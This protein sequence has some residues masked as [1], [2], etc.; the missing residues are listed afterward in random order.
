M[1]LLFVQYK[2]YHK[3]VGIPVLT[4]YLSWRRWSLLIECPA[5]HNFLNN[6]EWISISSLNIYLSIVFLGG[7]LR[8]NYIFH[9]TPLWYTFM[10]P[11]C[12]TVRT[13]HVP[14]S[15]AI[16]IPLFRNLARFREGSPAFI[17]E[18]F[19]TVWFSGAELLA[20]AQLPNLWTRLTVLVWS[21]N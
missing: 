2:F 17:T 5:W 1:C 15:I 13:F 10:L 18:L 6:A 11:V 12:R 16:F 14:N 4:C 9:L 8:Q 7:L 3:W 21:L 20:C 19:A